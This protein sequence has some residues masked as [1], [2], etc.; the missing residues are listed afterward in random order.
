MDC[1]LLNGAR[2]HIY[3]ILFPQGSGVIS[4]EGARRD[5]I[6][7][8]RILLS[9]CGCPGFGQLPRTMLISENHIAAGFM[10]IWRAYTAI[11][12]HRDIQDWAAASSHV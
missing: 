4:K 1:T 8:G 5:L 2:Y 11:W 9:S 10:L 12:S 6:A 3:I 7:R